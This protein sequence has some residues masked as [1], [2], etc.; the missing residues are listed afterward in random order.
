M[1]L[2][3]CEIVE[4]IAM[5]IWP[6]GGSGRSFDEA[7]LAAQDGNPDAGVAVQACF[8]VAE[9]IF[10]AVSKKVGRRSLV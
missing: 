3:K 9:G 6:I 5:A 7:L 4:S 1:D 10:A 8:S 2:H